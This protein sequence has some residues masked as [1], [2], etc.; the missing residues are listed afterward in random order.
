MVSILLIALLVTL[1]FLRYRH[2]VVQKNTQTV[3]P[4][5]GQF[6]FYKKEMVNGSDTTKK[7]YDSRWLRI[8]IVGTAVSGEYHSI[9][10]E[11]DRKG[12]TFSGVVAVADTVA[13]TNTADVS[14][15]VSAEG[16]TAIEQLR[17]MFDT[18]SARIAFGEMLE[19][20]TLTTSASSTSPVSMSG[21]ALTTNKAPQYIYKD[22]KNLFYGDDMTSVSCKD[23]DVL[24]SS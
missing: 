2:M 3:M 21:S 16:M 11:K 9:P 17:I 19:A 5:S 7:M 13:M 8:N 12:G 23:L 20:S 15:Q 14:W 18:K 10:A 4:S 6:C 1:G 22:T 24:K